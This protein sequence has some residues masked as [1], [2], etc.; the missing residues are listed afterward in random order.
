[1]G[2]SPYVLSAISNTAGA[3]VTITGTSLS[4]TGGAVGEITALVT[5]ANSCT[6]QA[7]IIITQPSQLMPGTINGD[8]EVCYLGN[9]ASLNE[10]TAPAGGPATIL[11]QWELS[12]NG[13]A[14]W[15]DV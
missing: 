6:A 3:A 9:P 1:G 10:V 5:D 11:F 4:F 15:S 7:T 2:T 13:G 14:S 12:L 8:Q